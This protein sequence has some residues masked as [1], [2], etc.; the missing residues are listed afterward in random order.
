MIVGN[1]VDGCNNLG[2]EYTKKTLTSNSEGQLE[3]KLYEQLKIEDLIGRSVM[4]A[5]S[6]NRLSCGIIARSSG[7]LQNFK[8]ICACDGTKIWDGNKTKA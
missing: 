7:V 2:D 8:K 5:N 3:I 1:V 6:T 4:I